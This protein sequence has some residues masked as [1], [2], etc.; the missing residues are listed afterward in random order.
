VILALG[1]GGLLIAQ[2]THLH[3]ADDN[4]STPVALLADTRILALRERGDEALTLAAR[5]SG[6]AYEDDFQA[7]AKQLDGGDGLLA[8]AATA[9]DGD[10]QERVEKAKT[11]HDAYVKAHTQVRKLDDGGDYDAAVALAVGPATSATFTGFTDDIGQALEEHKATFTDEI[12]RAGNGLG[13]L[14]VLGPLLALIVCALAATG[15]RTRLE[16]Y[17]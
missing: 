15:I 7:V 12:G 5:G 17:R 1:A 13:L 4:G 10:A 14:T 16:E 6:G 2:R 3:K 9:A 8:Q 11:E